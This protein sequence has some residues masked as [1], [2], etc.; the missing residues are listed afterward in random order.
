MRRCNHGADRD[1]R[2]RHS[3]RDGDALV[4]AVDGIDL[5]IE[6]GEFVAVT[7]PSGSGKSTFLYLMG[8]LAKPVSGSYKLD[9]IDV[10]Q[11]ERNALAAIRNRKLGF[12]FQNFNLLARMSALENVQVPLLY[13]QMTG[14]ERRQRAQTSLDALGLRDLASRTPAKL[15]GGEQQRVAI[16]RALVNDPLVLLADEPTGSVDATMGGEIMSIF[17]ELNRQKGLTILVVTHEAEVAAYAERIINF[18]DGCI[19]EDKRNR[20]K[21][22][23][24]RQAR[25]QPPLV[26]DAMTIA[27]DVT[28]AAV[29][30]KNRAT[31][32][33]YASPSQRTYDAWHCH[34]GCRHRSDECNRQWRKR[35]DSGAN[36]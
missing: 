29:Q 34:W 6:R 22:L 10:S 5:A 8:C 35:A 23:G 3:Y 9:G 21:K 20:R 31:R 12:V 2:P 11:L 25:T 26:A 1:Q 24:A 16:A 33:A 36:T 18:R 30:R 15:S 32:I 4:W 7:G 19:V 27:G 13:R 14:H 28:N 17:R